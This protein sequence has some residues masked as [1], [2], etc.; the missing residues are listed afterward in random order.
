[1]RGRMGQNH[2]RP[3][4]GGAAAPEA[5]KNADSKADSHGYYPDRPHRRLLGMLQ[6]GRRSLVPHGGDGR[7]DAGRSGDG[8][9][10]HPPRSKE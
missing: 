8:N 4:R 3:A 1:M 2:T 5:A 6:A 7:G 10:Y 9:R